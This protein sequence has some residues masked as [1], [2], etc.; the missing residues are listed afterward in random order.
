MYLFTEM[1]LML[2]H[3]TFRMEVGHVNSQTRLGR[4]FPITLFAM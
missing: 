2:A 1:T 4:K 3:I